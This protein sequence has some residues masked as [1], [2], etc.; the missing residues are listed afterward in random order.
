MMNG[1]NIWV[2]MVLI[3]LM[4]YINTCLSRLVDNMK[5]LSQDGHSAG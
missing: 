1:M 3:Y 4:Y 2:E 5:Y